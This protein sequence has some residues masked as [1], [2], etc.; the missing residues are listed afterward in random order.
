MP[1]LSGRQ[2]KSLQTLAHHLRPVIYIGKHGVSDAIMAALDKALCDHELIKIKF[3]DFKDEKNSLIGSVVAMTGS[4]LVSMIGNT[5]VLFRQNT[6]PGKRR[7]ALSA[8]CSFLA[9]VIIL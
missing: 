9:I 6:D 1:S 7:I 8:F 5:A 4:E 3:I 2:K